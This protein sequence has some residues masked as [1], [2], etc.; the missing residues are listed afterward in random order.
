ML[1]MEELMLKVMTSMAMLSHP[2]KCF[3]D[4]VLVSRGYR[5]D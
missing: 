4:M 2:I 5:T 3:P 1:R